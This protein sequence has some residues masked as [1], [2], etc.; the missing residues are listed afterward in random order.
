MAKLRN[1]V[2]RAPVLSKGGYHV[3]SRSGER[4]KQK[5]HMQ[6]EAR[7]WQSEKGANQPPSHFSELIGPS[8]V[9]ITIGVDSPT[10]TPMVM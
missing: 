1:P 2:A 3:K 8:I 6:R 9:S 10:S 4:H 5:Q 7:Q